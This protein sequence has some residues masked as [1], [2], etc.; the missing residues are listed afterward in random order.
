MGLNYIKPISERAAET[1]SPR[2]PPAVRPR[3]H[4]SHL[5]GCAF[6][7]FPHQRTSMHAR[8]ARFLLFVASLV[9]AT[10]ARAETGYELWLRYV[11]V[12][13]A[14]KLASYRATIGT[15]VI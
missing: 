15:I 9:L 2:R 3:S 8:L 10:G 1:R 13:D 11:K 5:P 6:R 14:A 7:R 4:I 12:A